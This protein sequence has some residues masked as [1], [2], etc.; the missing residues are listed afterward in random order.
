MK[1]NKNGFF[2]LSIAVAFTY[3]AFGAITNVAG[4]IIPKIRDSYQVSSSLSAILAATFFIAYGLT[5]IPWG[6]L[7]E[8]VGK[9]I[10][11][12]ISS[13]IMTASV[14][15]FAAVP[16]FIPNM[17][18]MFV[19]GV[20][21][22]GIQVALNPLVGDISEPEKYSRNLT[23]FMVL[24]GVGG[25]AAPQLVTLIKNL[26][27]EWTFNYWVFTG[28]SLLVTLSLALPKYPEIAK[29]TKITK[30][31]NSLSSNLT[32]ELLSKRP[33]I[34]I[35]ALGIFLY[36]GVE[37]GVANTIGFYLQDKL[38][39]GEVL[40]EAAEAAKNTAISNYWGG[41]LIGR[42]LGTFVLNK[43]SGG[44]AIMIYISLA[45]L[46]LLW[47]INA[48]IN[49]ALIA[50]P[51]IG[52]FISIMFPTIYSSA[53]NSFTKEYSSAV[54]GILCTAIIGGAV[55]GPAI[56][57]LAEMTQGSNPL[58]NWDM[59]LIIAFACYAYLFFVGFTSNKKAA[60]K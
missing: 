31:G 6:I 30:E 25:Y 42:L 5:S 16:G 34:Y 46:S 44:K 28:I 13:L 27:Y 29:A 7:M 8:K 60:T 14:F 20:G 56:A 51:L 39:I 38:N 22:T 9:K 26:G 23:L 50:F 36:V 49:Q 11:L 53:T 1:I 21:I 3:F 15:M 41:L 32:F 52:F 45:A 33:L 37:V 47:A 35:F 19:S 59:G 24:N 10:T 2:L 57:W 54:S 18:A 12:I 58:P 55:I 40:G 4:A 48:D 43:I 17:I